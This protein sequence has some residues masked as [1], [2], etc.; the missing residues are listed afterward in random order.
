[1]I[2]EIEGPQLPDRQGADSL[3]IP[4]LMA[5]CHV[6]GLSVAVIHDFAIHWSKSWGVTDVETGARATN[7]T[8]YQ[9]ASA[10]K[11]VAAMASLKAVET[12]LFGLE[13][14]ING[15]LTSWKLP[16]SPFNGDSPV[17]PRTLM[18]HTSGT[19]DGFGFPGYEPEVPLPTVQ[20]ILDGE[21]PSNVGPVR[22]VRPPLSAAHYSGG[23][24]MI[25]QLALTDA[26]GSAF[27]E[28][29][30]GGPRADRHDQQHVRT[31]FG[32]R[33]HSAGCTRSRLAGQQYGRAMARLPR[34]GCGR[35]LDHANRSRQVHDRRATDHGR[36]TGFV[37]H[38]RHYAGDGDAGGRRFLCRRVFHRAKRRRLVFRAWRQQL[39]IS[40]PVN[41][42][43]RQRLWPG[44]YD[45]TATMDT[46][47][48]R[49]SWSGWLALMAG[50]RSTSR[51]CVS[52]LR[53]FAVLHP[54]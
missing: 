12:G 47:W 36:A 49:K 52:P 6:P 25:R 8:L 50:I 38:P 22:L 18:S 11:P 43:P 42:A 17:T 13:Q 54:G 51:S 35:A 19:G 27:S 16:D 37:T 30:Q 14:D 20:Q 46:R 1:M 39:G 40:L 53:D 10:S 44:R 23:G 29:M 45:E 2:A 33:S 32:R 34:T 9:A 15:I 26:I 4:E 28:F 31:A 24:V 48:R 7:E 5:Y 3:T 21:S 41:C